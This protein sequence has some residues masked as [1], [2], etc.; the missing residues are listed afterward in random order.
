VTPNSIWDFQVYS[1]ATNIG[2]DMNRR[3]TSNQGKVLNTVVLKSDS[4][5]YSLHTLADVFHAESREKEEQHSQQLQNVASLSRCQSD[6]L[7]FTLD[8]FR[9]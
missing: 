9:R 8:L 3:D 7:K 6:F 1:P 2:L 4:S 5:A